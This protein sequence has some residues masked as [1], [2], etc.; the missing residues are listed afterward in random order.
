M[1]DNT[2]K[3]FFTTFAG[4][5]GIGEQW[6]MSANSIDGIHFEIDKGKLIDP[7]TSGGLITDP[8][9]IKTDNGYRMYY[10]EFKKGESEPNIIS[11]FSMW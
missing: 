5:F 9:V 7:N 2:Y 10:G 4:E 1:N 8:E 11:A 6:V 3:L